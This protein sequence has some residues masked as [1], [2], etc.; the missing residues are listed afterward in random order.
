MDVGAVTGSR[1]FRR[2]DNGGGGIR[3]TNFGIPYKPCKVAGSNLKKGAQHQARDHLIGHRAR[4]RR[5]HA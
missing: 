5:T 4:A 2:E 1:H 3:Y